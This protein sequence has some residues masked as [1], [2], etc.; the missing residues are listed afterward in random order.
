MNKNLVI[1]GGGDHGSIVIDVVNKLNNFNIIGYIDKFDKGNVLGTNYLGDDSVIELL[2][3][4]YLG[5]NLVIAIGQINVTYARENIVK[6][7]SKYNVDFPSIISPTAIIN[8][9]VK[10]G[11][12]TVVLDGVIVNNGCNIGDFTIIN[13]G[14][15]LEHN[16]NIGNFAH[17]AT[18][19]TLGGNVEI[20]D[21]TM[22]GAGACVLQYTK[23]CKEC[24]IGTGAVVIKDIMDPG[25]YV[26]NPAKKLN[27]II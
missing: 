10:I 21:F 15:I 3:K 12:G 23:I 20:G 26:G 24:M 16:S 22:I 17:I 4:N 5:L 14:A 2:I 7:Y 1:V 13:S 18:N 19:A 8:Q 6:F 27:K 11:K 25:T 9:N